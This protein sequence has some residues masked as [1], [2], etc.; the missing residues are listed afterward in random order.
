VAGVR[1]LEGHAFADDS[2]HIRTPARTRARG[3]WRL[4][5]HTPA[6][7]RKLIDSSALYAGVPYSYVAIASHGI[8]VFT[9]GACPLDAN[10]DVV[11]RDDVAAQTRQAVDNLLVALDAAGCA[12]EDVVKTTVYV[13]TSDHA[14]LAVAWRLVEEVFGTQG[15]PSTLLG[16]TVLGWPGQL[17][18]IEAVATRPE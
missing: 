7:P 4:G 17:V 18:E 11:G 1:D 15:P 6:V 9:A 5:W 13:A 12:A 14:E 3:H 10:G 16:V 2:S 8:A